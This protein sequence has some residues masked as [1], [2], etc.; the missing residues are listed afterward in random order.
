MHCTWQPIASVEQLPSSL[1]QTVA[2]ERR[3]RGNGRHCDTRWHTYERALIRRGRLQGGD[4]ALD[5]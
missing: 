3:D 1:S 5:E 2:H 4:L